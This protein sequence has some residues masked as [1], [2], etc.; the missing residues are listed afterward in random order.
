MTPVGI[1]L[2]I[3]GVALFVGSFFLPDR[4]DRESKQDIARKKEQIRKLME[5]ELDG[6]KLRV[7]EAT[8]ETVEFNME[9]SERALEKIA[10]EKIMAVSEYATTIMEEID[11]NHKEVLFLYDM[12]NDKQTDVKNSVR[13]AE[14]AVREANDAAKVANDTAMYATN[15]ANAA[16]EAVSVSNAVLN[17]NTTAAPSHYESYESMSAANQ[18]AD[19][20]SYANQST[21]LEFDNSMMPTESVFG[22]AARMEDFSFSEPE[23]IIPTEQKEEPA[24]PERELTEFEILEQNTKFN[25]VSNNNQM[26][27]KLNAE[28]VPVVDIA[29]QLS[30]GVG[31]VQLVIDLFK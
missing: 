2:L 17:A 8:N 27:L 15:V 21:P 23:V 9:K 25:N 13:H 16:S 26:I 29:R 7:N 18:G 5:S 31:E 3:I 24:K 11:R 20:V 1:V 6:M 22:M 19:N 14:A 28:G 10:S 30:L 12:L 4:G